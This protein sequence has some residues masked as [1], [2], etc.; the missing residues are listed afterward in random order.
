MAIG[1]WGNARQHKQDFGCRTSRMV[2]S[3]KPGRGTVVT[4]WLPAVLV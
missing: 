3:N 1:E 2:V 4:V